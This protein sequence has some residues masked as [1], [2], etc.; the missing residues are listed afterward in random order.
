MRSDRQPDLLRHADPVLAEAHQIAAAH[1]L[2]NPY[3]SQAERER[4]AAH[5]HA[6]AARLS[7]R[8][9]GDEER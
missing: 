5:H 9:P 6:E 7:R 2:L 1:A 8:A 4:R 3:E